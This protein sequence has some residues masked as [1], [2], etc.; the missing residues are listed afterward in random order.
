MCLLGGQACSNA[1]EETTCAPDSVGALYEQRIAP[2]VSGGPSSCNQCH[3]SG[4]SLGSVVSG[5]PCRTMACLSELGEVDLNTPGQ[6]KILA[7]IKSA[8][9]QSSLI[10][11]AIIQQE[12]DG[13]LEWI[14][15]SATCQAEACGSIS[16]PC[17]KTVV[18]P[19][20]TL[21]PS[22]KLGGC[23]EGDLTREFERLVWPWRGRCGACHVPYGRVPA[24]EWIDLSSPERTMYN[25]IGVGALDTASPAKSLFLTKPLATSDPDGVE[26]GGGDKFDDKT[27]P[28][29]QDLLAWAEYYAACNNKA[30]F[31]T[32]LAS[33]MSPEAGQWVSGN[34]PFTVKGNAYDPQDGVLEKGVLVWT[35]ARLK[36]R[37]GTGNEVV[38]QLPSGRLELTLTATDSDGNAGSRTIKF[39]A[40][41]SCKSPADRAVITNPNQ[42]DPIA[43]PCVAGCQGKSDVQS[44]LETCLSKS[45]T[46]GCGQCAATYLNC[47]ESQCSDQCKEPSNACRLCVT[48]ACGKDW[49]E[50]AAAPEPVEIETQEE[51]LS[52]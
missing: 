46:P 6:S 27:D 38:T 44:C 35:L 4:I 31:Q 25:L 13:M 36:D 10:T 29:Y 51:D 39:Y 32:P 52:D 40:G 47:S 18:S 50:C 17:G 41:G 9:P 11:K 43:W 33:I 49:E 22:P 28:T 14:T 8:I 26:H 45:L 12:Y 23:D 19:E 1:A 30:G 42:F 2:F 48:L 15:F 7:R 20:T 16:D 24:P 3:M 34:A 21:A 5:D 37:L